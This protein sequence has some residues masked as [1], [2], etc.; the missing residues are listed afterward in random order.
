MD[1]SYCRIAPPGF[2]L[3][4]S[5][6]QYSCIGND[7]SP[8]PTYSPSTIPSTA[9]VTPPITFAPVDSTTSGS[10]AGVNGVVALAILKASQTMTVTDSALLKT[11]SKFETDA[12]DYTLKSIGFS[13]SDVGTASLPKFTCG[14]DQASITSRKLLASASLA[15][16]IQA[17]LKNPDV[18]K[19]A[20]AGNSAALQSALTA[21]GYSVTVA[22]AIA[23]NLSPTASPVSSPTSSSSTTACF[24]GTELVVLESGL[25]K[26]LSDVQIG[27]RILSVNSRTGVNVFSDVVY[28]PHGK[29]LHRTVFTRILTELG[30]DLKMTPDH[31]LPAGACSSILLHPVSASQIKVGDCVLTITGREQ[32]VS[33]EQVEG[34]GI[35]T[36]IA[37]EELIVVNGIFATP[38]GGVNPKL[39]NTYYNLFRIGYTLNNVNHLKTTL[40]NRTEWLW[41]ILSQ[42]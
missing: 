34:E 28:L 21:A 33:V 23:T 25:Q 24:A 38:F 39:A 22:A 27:D 6:R 37:M 1:C 7:I 36:A 9:P 30:R 2:I 3:L 19:A 29:N 16:E 12:C 4:E 11:G 35:Y 20:L 17:A 42:M 32:V 10:V 31:I 5:Y 13:R 41:N 8:S 26:P 14:F 40:Q 18:L 15:Y